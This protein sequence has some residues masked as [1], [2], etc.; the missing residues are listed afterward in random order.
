[1]WL[2]VAISLLEWLLLFS[3]TIRVDPSITG[4]LGVLYHAAASLL[5]VVALPALGAYWL[6]CSQRAK[7]EAAVETWQRHSGRKPPHRHSNGSNSGHSSA[8][9]RHQDGRSSKKSKPNSQPAEA[10]GLG[11]THTARNA[12]PC[13]SSNSTTAGS[14]TGS[15]EHARLTHAAAEDDG[16]CSTSQFLQ[17]IANCLQVAAAAAA[18]PAGPWSDSTPPGSCAVTRDAGVGAAAAVP[19][20]PW[21]HSGAAA[22]AAAA[23]LGR[24]EDL[25]AASRDSS[26]SSTHGVLPDMLPALR[27]LLGAEQAACVFAAAAQQAAAAERRGRRSGR[28]VPRAYKSL[29]STLPVS[30]KVGTV[31]LWRMLGLTLGVHGRRAHLLGVFACVTCTG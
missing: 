24:L 31:G 18:S 9:T 5:F 28:A 4:L 17:D 25:I 13:S 30:I 12:R 8:Q 15:M 3:T 29:A 10:L 14:S 21:S 1:M 11:V 23:S 7:F 20:A 26:S 2:H 6:E 22:T 19:T 16:G 27:G